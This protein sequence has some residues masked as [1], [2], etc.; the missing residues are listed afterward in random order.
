MSKPL[1]YDDGIP[2]AP[3]ARQGPRFRATFSFPADLAKDISKLAKRL[4]VSQS[5]LLTE[6]L[7]DPI[8]AMVS[9]IDEIPQTGVRPDAVKRARGRSVDLIRRAVTEAQ[10]LVADE[11]E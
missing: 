6:L 7:T 4:G 3:D 11:P 2:S 10:Q 8:A 9:I 1:A 5:A